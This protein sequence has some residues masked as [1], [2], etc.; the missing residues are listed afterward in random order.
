MGARRVGGEYLY[1]FIDSLWAGSVGF[2]LGCTGGRLGYIIV[3]VVW[4]LRRS[5]FYGRW[6]VKIYRHRES[7]HL[8]GRKL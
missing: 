4:S 7:N 3:G 1:G 5:L 6:H 8:A 2:V